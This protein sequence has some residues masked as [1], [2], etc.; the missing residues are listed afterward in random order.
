MG[1]SVRFDDVDVLG[2]A[3]VHDCYSGRVWSVLIASWENRG[4]VP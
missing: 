3:A 4:A 1:W 2:C